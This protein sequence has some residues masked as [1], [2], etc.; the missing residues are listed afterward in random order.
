MQLFKSFLLSIV[1]V[2]LLL[3]FTVSGESRPV[4]LSPSNEQLLSLLK[5]DLSSA[6]STESGSN[7]DES[8]YSV[9]GS[10][11]NKRANQFKG[12]ELCKNVNC[13]NY[14]SNGQVSKT[15]RMAQLTTCCPNFRKTYY[16]A[17]KKN[18]AM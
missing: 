12:L 5:T 11:K 17:F 1:V 10:Y 4:D 15:W 2:A 18:A 8:I 9:R 16:A 14:H 7:E 3:V 13:E 6:S